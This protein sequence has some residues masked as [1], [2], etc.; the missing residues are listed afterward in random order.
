M[1]RYTITFSC[2]LLVVALS[3]L[4]VWQEGFD[5]RIPER[6]FYPSSSELRFMESEFC[7]KTNI[8]DDVELGSGANEPIIT[9]SHDRQSD[10]SIYVWGDSHAR[11]L[12]PGLVANFPTHNIHILYFTSCLAQSGIGAFVYEYEGRTALRN[13]CLDR[14]RRAMRFFK[15]EKSNPIILHQYSGYEGQYSEEWYAS[16]RKVIEELTAHE[17]K[18]AF[19]GAVPRPAVSL[20][21]CISVPNILPDW[22]LSKRCKGDP[23]KQREIFILNA[24]L[25]N[26]FSDN[27]INPN[28]VLCANESN[29]LVIE[30]SNLIYRDKHHLT[31]FG[32]KKLINGIKDELSQMLEID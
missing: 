2:T 19:I 1:S 28:G 11:H 27:F 31:I 25:E 5:W 22:L 23:K 13:A 16:T 8:L 18:I 29:C 4:I 7:N 24:K 30:G 6:R 20:A 9:C 26:N 12:L 21:E 3:V 14:N 10:K 17:N 15:K 32:S